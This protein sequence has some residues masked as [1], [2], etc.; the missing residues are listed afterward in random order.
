MRREILVSVFTAISVI[1]IIYQLVYDPSKSTEV[2]IYSF[3]LIVTSILITDFYLRM[4]ESKDKKHIFILKH[5][6]EIPALIPLLIF[7]ILESSSYLNVIFRL[8]RLIRL[9]R[10]I[11]L[12]SRILTLSS[13]TTNRFLYIIAVSGMAV[14]GGAIGLFLVEGNAPDSKVT[15]LGDAFWWAIVTVT[16]VGYGDIYPV[17]VEGKIIASMLMII[18]IAI[19]G[20]LISTLGASFI[21]SRLKPQ[22]NIAEEHKKAINAKICKLESLTKDEYSS[23][24]LSIN[25]LYND[26]ISRSKGENNNNNSTCLKCKNIYPENSKFCN[27]CGCSLQDN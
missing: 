14:S 23:L 19:L 26:L 13:Q 27:K 25:T 17:T 6:Y 15:N 1:I 4:K 11:H 5:V 16:T 10:I 8:L 24:I 2:I 18:G 22:S 21:E 7:G 20:V 12:Y 9:F 3:D